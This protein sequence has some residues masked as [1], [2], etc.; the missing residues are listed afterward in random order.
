[1]IVGKSRKQAT[2]GDF[3]K[4]L[5]IQSIDFYTMEEKDRGRKPEGRVKSPGVTLQEP[6]KC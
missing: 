1:L 5:Q 3:Q 2:E 4:L 6:G